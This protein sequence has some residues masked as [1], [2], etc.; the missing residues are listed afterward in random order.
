M[1]TWKNSYPKDKTVRG[2]FSKYLE[3][4]CMFPN[5]DY[6]DSVKILLPW[7]RY[8]PC[9]KNLRKYMYKHT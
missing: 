3:I 9:V 8:L 2:V 5:A 6:R 1:I 4:K 7:G